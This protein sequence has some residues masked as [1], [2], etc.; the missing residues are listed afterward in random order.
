MSNET[1]I[2]ILGEDIHYSEER[3]EISSL[4]YYENN[5]RVYAKLTEGGPLPHSLEERQEFIHNQMRDEKSVQKLLKTIKHQRGVTEPLVV[6][7]KTNEVI[8]GNSRLAALRYLSESEKGG[9]I[10]SYLTAP[11]RVLS[12]TPDQVDAYL[13]QAHVDGRTAWTPYAQAFC[14]YKRVIE[15]EEG[16]EKYAENTNQTEHAVQKQIDIVQLMKQNEGKHIREERFSYYESLEKSHK[17]K[18]ACHANPSLRGYLLKEIRKEKPA[19]D[20]KNLRDDIPKIANRRRQLKKLI[21]SKIDFETALDLSKVSQPKQHLDKAFQNLEAV[22]DTAIKKLP[23]SDLNI[24]KL[25][26][27]NCRK[28]LER[29]EKTL[30]G[31][32]SK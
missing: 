23:N 24:A 13:H 1:Y 20:A 9:D 11:C 27:K 31:A 30:K 17:L 12:L 29:I 25:A 8:E 22:K 26:M 19:F 18:N 16:I 32:L 2:T 10:E 28:E 5:P 15:D 21:E 4:K 7:V 14:T 6:L 3:L